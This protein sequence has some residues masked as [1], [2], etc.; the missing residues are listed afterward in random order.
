MEVAIKSCT[1][2][3]EAGMLQQTLE[4]ILWRQEYCKIVLKIYSWGR[5]VENQ[6]C[7][8]FLETGMLQKS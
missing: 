8:S 6:P 7:K 2:I 5:D 1:Y 3:Q 4:N